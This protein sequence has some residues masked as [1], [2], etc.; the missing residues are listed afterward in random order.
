MKQHLLR[1][2]TLWVVRDDHPFYYLN[3]ARFTKIWLNVGGGTMAQT[4]KV[5]ILVESLLETLDSDQLLKILDP[6]TKLK[7]TITI[8]RGQL[9]V[10]ADSDHKITQMKHFDLVKSEIVS[11]ALWKKVFSLRAFSDNPERAGDKKLKEVL[12][13]IKKHGHI[14]HE[15]GVSHQSTI[16][17]ILK[18][19]GVECRMVGF[20][21]KEGGCPDRFQICE[22]R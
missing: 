5:E 1:V 12:L 20:R 22:I 3:I 2:K 15:E 8:E 16:N 21:P 18:G 6:C 7:I 13:R 11:E 19:N 14:S 10:T 4:K 17:D 9:E